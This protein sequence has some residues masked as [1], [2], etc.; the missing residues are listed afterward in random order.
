[1]VHHKHDGGVLE[2][3]S[4]PGIV[5]VADAHAVQR[6]ADRLAE[7]VAD[8]EI[9]VG[10]ERRN[11][12]ARVALDDLHRNFTRHAL[13]RGELPRRLLH[14]VVVEEP[15]DQR[16]AA[17]SLKR[18]D[19]D[20]QSAADFIEHLVRAAAQEPARAGHEQSIQQREGGEHGDQDRHPQRHRNP[21]TCCL[22]SVAATRPGRRCRRYVVEVT[23]DNVAAASAGSVNIREVALQSSAAFGRRASQH[24]CL[25]N[26]LRAEGSDEDPYGFGPRRRRSSCRRRAHTLTRSWNHRRLR[27]R[28]AQPR[29]QTERDEGERVGDR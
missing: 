15:I 9:E 12:L 24:R 23:G 26:A 18:P 22:L 28:I 2:H 20:L 5:G 14:L 13:R 17:R 21:S 7:P 8:A 4:Q 3:R 25:A 10:I 29:E 6:A 27:Y 11:D 1:M 16:T 19:L